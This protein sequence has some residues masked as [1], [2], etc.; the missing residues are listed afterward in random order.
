MRQFVKS[1][2]HFS[3]TCATLLWFASRFVWEDYCGTFCQWCHTFQPNFAAIWAAFPREK[4][5][6]RSKDCVALQD[7]THF[8]EER[9]TQR[10]KRQG[11]RY[12]T[13]I[14]GG[15][16]GVLVD[17]FYLHCTPYFRYVLC[18]LKDCEFC[19][20][21]VARKTLLNLFHEQLK[22]YRYI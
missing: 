2:R 18:A 3:R 12:V 17:L 1:V 11:T 5:R 20:C 14:S 21:I 10:E 9:Q 7:G 15:C 13:L 19:E 16:S 6:D 22:W 4:H 8:Q